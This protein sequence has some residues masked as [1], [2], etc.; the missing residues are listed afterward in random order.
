MLVIRILLVFQL[1]IVFVFKKEKDEI[2]I[3][4]VAFFIL[5]HLSSVDM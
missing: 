5:I 4:F 2:S 1:V 3:N